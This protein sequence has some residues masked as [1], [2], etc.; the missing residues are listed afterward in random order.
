[1]SR[2]TRRRFVQT[3]LAA[4]GAVS[5]APRFARAQ[6]ANEKIGVANLARGVRTYMQILRLG[7]GSD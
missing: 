1:M 7:A 4:A 3:S 6:D 2:V 5:L